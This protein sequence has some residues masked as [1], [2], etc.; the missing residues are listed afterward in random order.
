[1]GLGFIKTV[2]DLGTQLAGVAIIHVQ[3]EDSFKFH[4]K[5]AS[6]RLHFLQGPKWQTAGGNKQKNAAS[7][8]GCLWGQRVKT[9]GRSWR[10]SEWKYRC[11]LDLQGFSRRQINAQ[12]VCQEGNEFSI[13]GL[14]AG[15]GH[16]AAEGFVQ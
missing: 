11:P 8:F 7:I 12:L 2:H 9:T 16:H 13:G 4:G 5:T 14:F 1:M 6:F 10:L 15:E 3:G